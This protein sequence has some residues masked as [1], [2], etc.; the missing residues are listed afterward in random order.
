[1]KLYIRNMVCHR[2]K[3][4][5]EGILRQLKLHPVSILLGEAVLEEKSL[6]KE[7]IGILAG[8]LQEL[9]FELIDDKRS[10]L[11][12]QIKTYIIN[13]VHYNEE[14]P[15]KKISQLLSTRLHHDYS[16]LSKLFSEVEG[17]TIEQFVINQR[18][19]K[20]KEL[21]IYDESSLSDIAFQLGYSSAAHLSNQ[22]KKFTG[23]TPSHFK[24]E[25][26]QARQSLDKAGTPK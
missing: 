21:L 9:G 2:C 8:R 20:V 24:K 4:A 13:L 26:T 6:T 14:R 19:E 12:E 15:A 17:M 22:F 23:M 3:L 16:Y 11:I 1:M 25:G 7:Q 10:K 5:V 18:I